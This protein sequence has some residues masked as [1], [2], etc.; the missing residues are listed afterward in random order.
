MKVRTYVCWF[1]RDMPMDDG[2]MVLQLA[3]MCCML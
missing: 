1:L 2:L 3:V